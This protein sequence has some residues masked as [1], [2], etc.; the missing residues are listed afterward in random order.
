[1][2]PLKIGN[3]KALTVLDFC[4][5]V[6]LLLI[7][8]NLKRIFDLPPDKYNFALIT[9]DQNIYDGHNIIQYY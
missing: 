3:T 8:Q 9:D 7:I 1:M 5:F 2:L 6:Q 4:D